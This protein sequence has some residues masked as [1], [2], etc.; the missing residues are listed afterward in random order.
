MGYFLNFAPMSYIYEN[1]CTTK[2]CNISLSTF[3]PSIIKYQDKEYNS[4]EHLFQSLRYLRS[5]E[6]VDQ[7]YAEVIRQVRTPY[8]ARLLGDQYIIDRNKLVNLTVLERYDSN[9]GQRRDP[10]NN[11]K[12][13]KEIEETI[14]LFQIRGLQ[15]VH[16]DPVANELMKLAT[17]Q[18]IIQNPE[19][20]TVLMKCDEEIIYYSRYNIYWGTKYICTYSQGSSYELIGS[21]EYGKLLTQL[22]EELICKLLTQLQDEMK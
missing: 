7:E 21:N 4:V 15:Q 9:Y 12:W 22:R 17:I 6:K 3:Y 8:A 16:Y 5:S 20:F 18:K 14:R 11:S 19:I 13:I 2:G 1:I 10:R